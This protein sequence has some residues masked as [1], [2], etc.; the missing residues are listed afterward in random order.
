MKQ[1]EVVDAKNNTLLNQQVLMQ[2]YPYN[3]I[4]TNTKFT[5]LSTL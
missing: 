5:K 1:Y 3:D 2:N 4:F